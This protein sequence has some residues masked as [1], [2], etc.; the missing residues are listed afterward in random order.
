MPQWPSWGDRGPVRRLS[1]RDRGCTG[2]SRLS[3]SGGGGE[4]NDVGV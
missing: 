2:G 1:S 3:I 4:A